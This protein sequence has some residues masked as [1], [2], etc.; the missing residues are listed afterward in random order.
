LKYYNTSVD[1]LREWNEN[2]AT[3]YKQ[4]ILNTLKEFGVVDYPQ[5]GL[6]NALS[7]NQNTENN[8]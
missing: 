8:E 4:N 3:A 2:D 5:A 6:D 1:N 7:N